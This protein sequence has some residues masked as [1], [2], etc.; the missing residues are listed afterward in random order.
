M[1]NPSHQPAPPVGGN[2]QGWNFCP[3]CASAIRVD[4]PAGDDHPRMICSD[5]E[6]VFYENPKVIVGTIP[7]VGNRILLCKRS[8]EPRYGYWTLPS[9]FMENN[10]TCEEGTMRETW[11][12]ARAR[13]S[14]R[15]LHTV[16]NIPHVHQVYMLF[17]ADVE[18]G[19]FEPGPESLEC[20]LVS[21]AEIPWDDIAFRAVEF[22]LRRLYDPIPP[23]GHHGVYRRA[24]D[25]PWT[26]AESS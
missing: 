11:E 17:A 13:V 12:E 9:G 2:L 15:S 22:A 8:I 18:D 25:E 7:F 26:L 14:I 23:G 10:E 1:T 16:F 6:R 20:K 19:A 24:P 5:C 4:I 3:V 21:D